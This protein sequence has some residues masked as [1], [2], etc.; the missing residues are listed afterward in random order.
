MSKFLFQNRDTVLFIGD[1]ITDCGRR[2]QASP[3]GDGYVKLATDLITA[4]YPER[5]IRYLNKGISGNTVRDLFHRWHDD[6]IRH[7]P[8]WLSIK[9][10]INDLAKHLSGNP[11][12]VNIDEYETRYEEIL[13]T[14]K[15]KTKAHIILI[16]PFLITQDKNVESARGK[17]LSLLPKYQAV[18]EKMVK[19]YKTL[20]VRPHRAF[21]QQLRYRD[22]DHFCPEPVHP[23]TSGHLII[24]HEFLRTVGW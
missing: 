24:A 16:D 13:Q 3:L 14:A 20:H 9:I 17:R 19:K 7:K 15:T 1:S 12:G 11:E 23:N 10:G 21:E 5:K 2:A 6:V 22:A 4:R 8:D 18:V